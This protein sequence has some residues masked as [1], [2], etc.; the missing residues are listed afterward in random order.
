MYIEAL[1]KRNLEYLEKVNTVSKEEKIAHQLRLLKKNFP[2]KIIPL[3]MNHNKW[4]KIDKKVEK[5]NSVKESN[6][7]YNSGKRVP[8]SMG[9]VYTCITGLYDNLFEPILRFQDIKYDVFTDN[10]NLKCSGWNTRNIETG[11][12]DSGNYI[13]RYYKF[14]PFEVEK[15][16]DYSIYIDGNVQITSDVRQLYTVAKNSKIGIA[17]HTHSERDCIYAEGQTCLLHGRGN[18]A[19]ISAQ[20][21]R[22]KYEG[23]PRH[24]GLPEA[25]IIVVDHH[26]PAAKILLDQW[27]EEFV[28]WNAGRDQ[29]AF[30]YILWKNGY[31]INDLGILGN[32]KFYNPKFLIHSHRQRG[33]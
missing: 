27:W 21:D 33:R 13:N 20:L 2:F 14:H 7:F 3:F 6:F 9:A 24:F 8:G 22:Y 23:M 15:E 11:D 10:D 19:Q 28:F 16:C 29:L 30:P 31:C 18:A 32:N 26:N 12:I 4:A 1:E 5:L 17:M 25:T